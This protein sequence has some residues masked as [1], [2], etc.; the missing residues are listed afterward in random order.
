MS[1]SPPKDAGIVPSTQ[2]SISLHNTG[3][4]LGAG[5]GGFELL[6][7]FTAHCKSQVGKS[8][9]LLVPGDLSSPLPALVT[10]SKA[11]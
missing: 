5:S 11:V 10:V 8:L 4:K 6:K 7:L 2:G 9:G 3:P 1:P